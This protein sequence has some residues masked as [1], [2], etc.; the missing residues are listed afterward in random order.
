MGVQTASAA[1]ATL[2]S[3]AFAAATAERYLDRRRPQELAWTAALGFFSVAAGATWWG[4]SFGWSSV[5]F[6]VFYAFGAVVNVPV[7][8]IGTVYLLAPP[9]V[10]RA[11]AS[12]T[13]VAVAF[14]AGVVFAAPL[15]AAMP[16]DALPQG[17]DVFGAGPRAIAA[18]ASTLGACVL[19]GGA[20]WSIAGL[21]R[22]R[23]RAQGR[24]AAA[25]ALIAA[26]TLVLS[27]GGLVNSV[28][29]EMEAFALTLSIGVVLLFCGF[30][31]TGPRPARSEPGGPPGTTIPT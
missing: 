29:D 21:S 15:R 9:R 20:L 27:L 26:G 5:S 6:R 30:L 1:C 10:A 22:R 7:L 13:A 17:S 8:A 28:L 11:V 4:A 19:F 12:A 25:N 24:L 3:M 18:V 23:A 2:V 14:G 31:F 16:I